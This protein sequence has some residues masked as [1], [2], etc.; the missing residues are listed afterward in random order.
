MSTP[1]AP[2]KAPMEL[3]PRPDVPAK[4]VDHS[5]RNWTIA[6]VI[7]IGLI[8]YGATSKNASAPDSNSGVEDSGI[9]QGLGTNDASGDVSLGSCSVDFKIVT[10]QVNIHNNSDGR[11]D[12]FIEATITDSSG[13]NVGSGNAFATGV[14]GGQDA[15]T[16]L[17]G[18]ISGSDENVNVEITQIQRTAS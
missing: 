12:Y 6:V 18:V 8:V 9:D 17:T 15:K 7:I 13:T 14:E 2:P 11:S 3:P 1:A 16:D 10:C 5:A 4:R